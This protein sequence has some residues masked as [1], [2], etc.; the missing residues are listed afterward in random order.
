MVCCSKCPISTLL[1][2]YVRSS[3]R[4]RYAHIWHLFTFCPY[5][6]FLLISVRLPSARRPIDKFCVDLVNYA[7]ANGLPDRRRELPNVEIVYENQTSVSKAAK[8]TRRHPDPRDR[9]TIQRSSDE[10]ALFWISKLSEVSWTLSI[11]AVALQRSEMFKKRIAR[12]AW[13]SS[14]FPLAI[15][16]Y[17]FVFHLIVDEQICNLIL[18]IYCM[19]E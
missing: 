4:V 15:H 13:P 10:A 11:I 14:L 2:H 17:R 6:N 12:S 5:I 7:H 3:V 19:K 8:S 18:S 16:S 1:P 9:L